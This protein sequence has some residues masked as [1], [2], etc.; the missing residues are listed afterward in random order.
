VQSTVYGTF[1]QLLVQNSKQIIKEAVA[2][3]TTQNHTVTFHPNKSVFHQEIHKD[4]L[5]K[6]IAFHSTI[7]TTFFI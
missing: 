3:N 5:N 6:V 2:S 4:F 1:S 7:I